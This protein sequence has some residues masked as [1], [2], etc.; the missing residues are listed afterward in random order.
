[1]RSSLSCLLCASL[2]FASFA[3]ATVEAAPS[4]K[5][6]TEAK[7]HFERAAELYSAEDYA[8]A[9]AEFE[10]AYGLDP[11]IDTL[12]AWAQAERLA[13][14][15]GESARLYEE[16]LASDLSD[17]QH[18][19][20]EA[21]LEEVRGELEEAEAAAREE[22]E[23]AEAEAEAE[24]RREQ[25]ERDAANS[26]EQSQARK[27]KQARTLNLVLVGGGAVLSAVGVGLLAGGGAADGRVGQATT[28]DEFESAFDPSTQRGRGAVPMYAAGGTLAAVG[29]GLLITGVVRMRQSKS[30][31]PGG[32]A[33]LPLVSPTQL[34]VG[35]V[36]RAPRLRV[37]AGR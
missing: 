35:L 23:A 18:D 36:L 20:V 24:R 17:T 19:A 32:V 21:L 7:A 26:E 15:L 14:D 34:G 2:V 29:L 10:Q 31:T 28:Y 4:R 33:V 13:G 25:A 3:P 37:G 6:R 1:M 27:A 8:G 12:F 9:A 11:R 16:L 30:E 22:R 5:Q